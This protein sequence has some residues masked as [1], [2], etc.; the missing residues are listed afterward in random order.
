MNALLRSILEAR[1]HDPFAVLGMHPAGHAWEV[2]AYLPEADAAFVEESGGW[3]TMTRLGNTP[4]FHATAAAAMPRPYRLAVDQAG[5]RT[6][7]YD[8]YSFDPQLSD[9]DLY[10]FGEG[11]LLQAW[12]TLGAMPKSVAGVPG[13]LFATWA[14]NA[15]RVSVVGDFNG[16]D[17]RRHPMRARGSSGV[18]ELFL[19]GIDPGALYKFELRHRGS[20]VVFTKIDPYGRSFE[21]RPAT[22]ARVVSDAPFA[23][24]DAAWM[25]QRAARDWLRAPMNCY[26]VHL[27]SWR[28][29]PEGEFLSYEELARGLA[30]H[31]HRLG[32]THVE[33]LPI[34]EHPL[35]ESWGYQATGYFAPTSRFGSPDGFRSFVDRLHASGIGVIVD[36]VPGHFPKDSWALARF[37]GTALYEHDDPRRGEHPDWGTLIFN[38]ERNEVRNFLIAG[39]LHWLSEFHVDG[40]RV[41]AVASMLYLDYSRKAGAWEPNRYGGRENLDAIDFLREVNSLVH[42]RHPGAVTIAEEST[43]WPMVSRPTYVGGLGFSMKWNM[44]WMNDTLRYISKDP[45]YR[46]FHQGD[47]TFSQLYAYTENFVLPLSHDEV[48]HGKGSLLD[49]M[50]GDAWQKF[51]NMRLLLTYQMTH[52]GKKLLF[53]GGEFAQGLEWNA[54]RELDWN[55]LAIAP[56]AQTM[57]TVADLNHL[58]VELAAL[59]DRDFESNGFEWIDCHDADASVL[60]FLRRGRNGELAI[61]V[62]NFT[63]VVRRDYRIGVPLGGDYREVFNSDATIY[64]GSNVGNAG[65]AHSSEIGWMGRSHSLCISLPPLAGVIFV[66]QPPPS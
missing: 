31:A 13:V 56:H 39:A 55:L 5:S 7:R 23:W 42:E 25:A 49:K 16:W 1:C 19:P 52:P 60:S 36:W 12:E 58:Y 24:N 41:D 4:L 61:V 21:R 17:G 14:P 47:L 38:Y 28:R 18:W 40:L 66:P 43:A 54:S 35:D 15:E 45:I 6:I 57:R 59:H 64:G 22:A 33:L 63:P 8:P 26:E 30:E 51:A 48:V 27:G 2:R 3:R 32:Y 20:G 9:H 10:L 62:L 34:A 46:H 53:M 29:S 11:R 50:P 37:D 44:G 65:L